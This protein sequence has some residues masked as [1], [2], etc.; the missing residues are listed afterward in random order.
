MPW[1]R[2][3]VERSCNL[4]E[5]MQDNRI[6]YAVLEYG[7]T[8]QRHDWPGRARTSSST[9]CCW[10]TRTG[11]RIQTIDS[12]MVVRNSTFTDMFGPDEPPTTDN[13]S[14]Q[15]HG[16]GIAAGG[17]MIIENN[18]F[19][20]TKGHNDVIDF[21]G[22]GRPGPILQVLGNTFTGS[23][24]EI[25][26]LGGDAYIE[27]NLFQ[28][29]HKDEFNIGSGRGECHL[30]RGRQLRRGDYRGAERVPGRRPCGVSEGR[31]VPVLREQ[32]GDRHPRRYAGRR[33]LGDQFRDSRPRSARQGRLSRAATSSRTSRGGFLAT[34]TELRRRP[35]WQ[36]HH[37]LVPPSRAGD[38]VGERPGTILDLGS[39]NFAGDP[40]LVDTVS[41]FRLRPGSPAIGTGPNGLDMGAHVPAGA[42]ISGEPATITAATA[43][44]L[45][46]AGPGITHYRF[47]LNDGAFGPEVAG[48]HTD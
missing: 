28:N 19:G 3:I 13:V 30:D 5:P 18:W 27:G 31:H 40:A 6:A 41:D 23:G 34:S 39:G 36:M 46:V 43:A 21:S 15:I 22:P 20:T 8:D 17:Q 32:H 1:L 24:D 33:I 2:C 42:S 35:T 12:S 9:T 48:R 7:V 45:T 26:D 38:Q 4:W 25:L 47:R 37:T 14:E 44:T 16:S 10:T 29:V 11:A